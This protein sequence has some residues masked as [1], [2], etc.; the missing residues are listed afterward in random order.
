[1][2]AMEGATGPWLRCYR[3]WSQELEVQE[4]YEGV[5]R[6]DPE[7]GERSALVDEVREAV[8][9]CVDCRHDQPH[10]A[11]HDGRIEPIEDRWERM[12]AGMPRVASCVVTV[13]GSLVETCTGEEAAEA[14]AHAAFGPRGTHEFFTHIRFHEH[15]GD[16]VA[17]HMLVELYARTP[18]E[19]VEMLED[20]ARGRLV[21]ASLA[22]ESRMPAPTG[23]QPH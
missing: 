5:H 4:R 21:I 12:V 7:T 9:Q 23:E 1:M 8:V 11:F 13:D 15:H 19:A 17:V 2:V 20:A 3:C 10:L 18:E 14:L 16:E 6:I 22:E